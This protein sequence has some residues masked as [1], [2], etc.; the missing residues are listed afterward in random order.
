MPFA[1]SKGQ[2]AGPDPGAAC[3][4]YDASRATCESCADVWGVA[5]CQPSVAGGHRG[6]GDDALDFGRVGQATLPGDDAREREAIGDRSTV[7]W[8][9]SPGEGGE[10]VAIVGAEVT[11]KRRKGS[12]DLP[13]ALAGDPGAR[14]RD[15]PRIETGR[16]GAA[17][18]RLDKRGFAGGEPCAAISRHGPCV[19]DPRPR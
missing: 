8:W 13:G 16:R 15:Q 11:C 14:E 1:R 19:V 3:D 9:V 2:D 6:R 18:Q 5:S 10:G 17:V 7:T 4:D 12:G